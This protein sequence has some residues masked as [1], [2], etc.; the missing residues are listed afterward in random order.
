M[1]PIRFTRCVTV[2]LFGGLGLGACTPADS[3]APTQLNHD[4]GAGTGGVSAGDAQIGAGG[5]TGGST[6]GAPQPPTAPPTAPPSIPPPGTQC[7]ER[8]P[9]AENTNET[10]RNGIDDD[11]DGHLD[12]LD[13]G[14]SHNPAVTACCGDHVPET[15]DAACSNGIDDDCNGFTDCED[16]ACS[17]HNGVHVCCGSN[18]GHTQGPE[19][20]E[21]ACADGWDNDC[22]G[23]RDCQDRACAG[24]AACCPNG[25]KPE[26]D[27]AACSNGVDDDCN[28]YTDCGDF[29]CS[30]AANVTIC[31][32]P[33]PESTTAACTDRK[34]NDCDGLADC[35][36]S[37]CKGNPSIE[38]CQ[39]P[40]VPTGDEGDDA[41]CAN[42][43][44][45]DCDGY[46]DCID[47]GCSRNPAITVCEHGSG[48]PCQSCQSGSDCASGF[49]MVY[50]DYPGVSFCT[51]PCTGDA[52]CPPSLS[53]CAATGYCGHGGDNWQPVCD[54]DGGGF[55]IGD[56]CGNTFTTQRCQGADVCNVANHWATCGP[57]CA[58]LYESIPL[59]GDRTCCEGLEGAF[60]EGAG[61]ANFV[62]FR[63]AG[64]ACGQDAECG[65][66]GRCRTGACLSCDDLG[67]NC[68]ADSD[69]CNFIGTVYC[70][71][72]SH[73]C[74]APCGS[75]CSQ[76]GAGCFDGICNFCSC[77]G[78]FECSCYTTGP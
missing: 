59:V 30:R 21:E 41:A 4:A 70:N 32:V 5:S 2:F 27:N 10:C 49:C 67:R 19:N 38:A 58:G 3:G 73:S 42:G 61:D 44:D 39:P 68:Q 64:E 22:N 74:E 57:P 13:F 55:S 17:P 23:F 53:R 37:D 25:P 36:D 51:Q 56:T 45:D 1:Q 75:G 48:T 35:D 9:K 14:C 72:A 33:E 16:F 34:D 71:P 76:A 26:S 63:T 11:C 20:T 40:C 15:S 7:G 24:T 12:C 62:C 77:E 28:G 50:N 60:V 46:V 65:A 18:A 69:C 43:V 78:R 54:A 29:G 8:A 52:D 6:G 31:C 47:F 66:T